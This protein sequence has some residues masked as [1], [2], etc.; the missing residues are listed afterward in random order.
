MIK[1]LSTKVKR[2]WASLALLSVEMAIVSGLFFISLVTFV[3]IVRRVFLLKNEELDNRIFQALH[4]HINQANTTVMNFITF[5]GKHEFLIPANLALIAYYLFLKKHKWYSIKVPAI[6]ISSFLLMFGLKRLFG[7][8]RPDDQL[9]ETATNFSFP[10]GHALMGVTFY[11]LLA[12]VA[13]HSVK[14][15]RLKWTFIVCSLVWV[16]AIGFS[17]IYL[18]K[19]Y[20][21]DVVAGYCIG[22]L[23]LSFTLW[24]LNRMEKLG[25]ARLNK[26]VSEPGLP[27]GP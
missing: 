1:R 7:R 2:F 15:V 23:W 11:G 26:V 6:A 4:P 14:S 20:F 3:Y 27:A 18:R 9:L 16:L 5:F 19:H 17:R 21:S 10:S 8:E 22:F 12:Y 13:W 25:R 24:F